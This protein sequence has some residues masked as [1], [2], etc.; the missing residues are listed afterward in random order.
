MNNDIIKYLK[1]QNVFL[2]K[3]RLGPH[4]DGGY[5]MPEFILENCNALM[6]YG[7]G[8]DIRY[9]EEFSRLY[10][11]NVYLF[12]HTIENTGWEKDKL[13]FIPEGLGIGEKCKE[14]YQH[15]EELNLSGDVFLKIDIEGGEF[16]Y[17]NTTDLTKMA[18]KVIGL[19]LEIHWIDDLN[20]RIQAISLLKKLS[21]N[22]ILCHIHGNSWGDLWEYDGY[23]IP[24]VLELSFINKKFVENFEPDIQKYPIEGLDISNC[25]HREDYKLDFI[26]KEYK[27]T[28]SSDNIRAVVTLTTIPSR[29]ISTYGEDI[30]LCLDSLLNQSFNDYEI[31]F[32]I[33]YIFKQTGEEYRIPDWLK[34]L[35]LYNPK[36]KIF[37][38]EDYGSISK[39][40]D[41]LKRIQN[42]ECIII[43]ADDDLI[44]HHEMVN[45]QVINQTQKFINSAVGYDGLGA[46]EPVFGDIR[47]HYV[48]SIPQNVKV[49]ILQ[50]YKTVSYKRKWFKEDFFTDFVGQSWADDIVVS[51]YMGKQKIDKIV[52]FY[53]NENIPL[54]LEDWKLFGGVS[55]F[56]VLR[57]TQHDTN[58]G[59]NIMRGNNI[60]DNINYFVQKGY[61]K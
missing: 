53:E 58:E 59:C 32:N 20:N 2:T 43:T 4:E 18:E 38:G 7:V 26:N 39:I 12:D 3:K 56:P 33:P 9:E 19:S 42:P 44:Y 37:R 45:Q 55:T 31:H 24:K 34:E 61:L 17:I 28:P 1:P 60:T 15:Y 50:H 52:T 22:F 8:N 10:N 35:S 46:L 21:D 29:L 30:K 5:V 48:V 16:N 36:L 41:T 23:Q 57:H 49:N 54:T 40:V 14:W 47:D 25:P 6:T 51:A 27:I 11:K 13:K